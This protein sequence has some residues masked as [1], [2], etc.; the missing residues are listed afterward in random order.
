[1]GIHLTVDTG[2]KWRLGPDAQYVPSKRDFKPEESKLEAFH[3]AAT[4]LL[5][6]GNITD[7][8]YDFCGIRPK[9]RSPDEKEEK[10][11]IISQDLPGFINLVGIESPG[12][13][14]SLAMAEYVA[15]L[16]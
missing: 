1:L 10:D 4:K 9:L 6:E 2:G 13:T 8:Q 12:L 5:G 3:E 16:F 15:A 11:F 7:L 14:A